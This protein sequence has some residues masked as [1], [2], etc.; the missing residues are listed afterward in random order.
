MEEEYQSSNI[1]EAWLKNIYEQLRSLQ[2]LERMGSEGC[3]NLGEFIQIPI[4]LQEIIIPET[5]YKNVRFLALEMNILINNLI[6]ILEG[7]VEK[8]KA[9][10]KFILKNIDNKNLFLK[11]SKRNNIICLEVMPFLITTF[12]LL[13]EIKSDIIKDIGHLLYIKED[14]SKKW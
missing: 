14:K 12:N 2:D 8:Y 9:R 4:Q 1:N 10:L 6:P 13:I 7:D 5:R 11:S 3:R